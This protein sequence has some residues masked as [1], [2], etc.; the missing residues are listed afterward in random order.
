MIN[1]SLRHGQKICQTRLEDTRCIALNTALPMVIC[2][3][4][5]CMYTSCEETI[6]SQGIQEAF[7]EHS[8][9]VPS[10]TR[11]LSVFGHCFGAGSAF[12]DSEHA[13]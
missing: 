4:V 1:T 5:G 3:F 7:R 12:V 8:S 2:L 11:T 9:P 6:P 10:A 13:Y